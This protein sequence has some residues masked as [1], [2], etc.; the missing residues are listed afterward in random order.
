MSDKV[1]EL[2]RRKQNVSDIS[3]RVR[4]QHDHMQ[5]FWDVLKPQL[6]KVGVP[7][8]E[9]NAFE[10]KFAGDITTPLRTLSRAL[11]KEIESMKAPPKG[12]DAFLAM[13]GTLEEL[14][15]KRKAT[16]AIAEAGHADTP[17]AT[18]ATQTG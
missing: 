4:T 14:A 17:K 9:V 8:T 11:D 12:E 16:R 3:R 10:P 1:A 7:E 15:K 18:G 5:S 6:I 13:G 2:E